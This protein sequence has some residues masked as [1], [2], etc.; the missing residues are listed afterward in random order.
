MLGYCDV[1]SVNLWVAIPLLILNI[2]YVVWGISC[3]S[4]V[5]V[6][7]RYKHAFPIVTYGIND[8]ISI[9][10]Y[11]THPGKNIEVGHTL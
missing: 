7:E 2:E 1:D 5:N 8:D 4:D 11:A 6:I 3:C 9:L 10:V